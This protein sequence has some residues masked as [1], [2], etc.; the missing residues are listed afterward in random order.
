MAIPR[1]DTDILLDKLKK[2][3]DALDVSI[4]T[5]TVNTDTLETL[6]STGTGAKA[7]GSANSRPLG[8]MEGVAADNAAAVGNP[9]LVGGRYDDSPRTL[10]SGDVGSLS[11]NLRGEALA[12]VTSVVPGIAATSLG[13]SEDLAHSSGDTGVFCL[14]VRNDNGV[15][16]AQDGD[17]VPFQTDHDGYLYVKDHATHTDDVGTFTLGTSK[18]TMMMGYAGTNSV[19]S[20]RAGAVSMDTDGA[21]HVSDGGNALTV[22]GSVAIVGV[23]PGY[24]ATALGK[25]IGVAQ[26]AADTGVASLAVRNDS[27]DDLAGATGDYAPLQVNASGALYVDV[28]AGSILESAVDG[29]D[30]QVLAVLASNVLLGTI[31]ADTNAIKTAV[32]TIDN[33]ISGSEMQVDIV[34]ALPA[35]ANAI[36]KLAA[37]SGVD[38]GDVD[39]TNIVPGVAATS[40]GKAE[41]AAAASGDTG[42]MALVVRKDVAS[43]LAQD[44]DYQPMQCD[45]DGTVRTQNTF[46]T[47]G[48]ILVN[49]TT[50]VTCAVHDRNFV[51]IY[52][53]TNTVFASGAGGLTST[54]D[55]LYLDDTFTG[56]DIDADAGT[57]IDGIT[58]PAGMTLYGRYDGFTLA[59]GSVIAYVG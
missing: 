37:N 46:G 24:G 51:A 43:C 20:G 41:D 34:A 28:A 32:E 2:A 26:G 13:K 1:T 53:L 55:Q 11:V 22:D 47:W 18:G 14:A 8:L 23:T 59:S 29:I 33:A 52:M 17:Y 6:L 40:L 7:G 9:V 54:T 42:V 36:G 21:L 27:L 56:T 49:D 50:A 10:G 58:F 39:V 15:C 12:Q 57:A 35:G 38:I 5:V 19:T 48:T 3:I 31:D 30:T 16:L 45:V 44:G 25:N 4:G